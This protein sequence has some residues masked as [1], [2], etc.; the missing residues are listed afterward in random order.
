MTLPRWDSVVLI[1]S[2]L[3]EMK[4][5]QIETNV[6]SIFHSMNFRIYEVPNVF[7]FQP[8]LRLW[9]GDLLCP[10]FVSLA[11]SLVSSLFAALS[12]GMAIEGVDVVFG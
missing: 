8:F 5:M 6:L 11:C 9:L 7:D 1:A 3:G 4:L 2:C 12:L 10:S